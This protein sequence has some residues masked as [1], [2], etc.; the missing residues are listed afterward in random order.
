MAEE[1]KP[2]G[3]PP[4]LRHRRLVISTNVLVQIVVLLVVVV[5]VNWLVARHYPPRFD[6]TSTHYYE[7]APKTR[8]VLESLKEPLDIV[9]FIPTGSQRDYVEK[10]LQD[11]RNLLKEFEVVG[12]KN[13][14]LE[15]VD[16]QRDLARA[17]ELVEKY[18][19]DSPD[20]VI[21]ASGPRHKFVKLDDMVEIEQANYTEAPRVKAFKGEGVFL[22]AIQTVT[23]EKPAKVYFLSGHGERDSDSTDERDGYSVFASYLKRDNITVEKWNWATKQAWPTDAG[24]LVVAGPR[25]KFSDA[26]LNALD[27]YL[28]NKGRVLMLL[29]PRRQTGVEQFL[30]KYG[31]QVDDDLVVSPLLGM[32][33][34]TA[35][36]SEYG[37]HPITA[38]MD[39]INTSFPYARS[40]REKPE[41]PAGNTERPDVVELVRTPESFWGE[42]DYTGQNL[43]FDSKTDV[44]GPVCLGVAVAT[45]KPGGVDIDVMRMVV[46]G[47]ASFVDNSNIRSSDGNADLVM[48]AINWLLKR[49]QLVAVSPKTPEEFHLD[50]SVNQ[51]R[52]V[53][54]LVV[55]VLP[56]AVA[57]TGIIVWMRRRR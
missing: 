5:M 25:T 57:L 51:V 50:M 47:T 41:P 7:L 24:V 26:E 37:R 23:E 56:L 11:V 1:L 9:V 4:T 53:Y 33:N 6:W 55:V 22:S 27:E 31:V 12:K 43:T 28:K 30:G 54:A 10:T 36:G 32:I 2:S 39:G 46:F 3:P 45:R 38:K 21:F 14:R 35:L 29:D 13:L 44:A 17:R 20:V 48:N 18:Q 40:V 52:M 42:T 16:P 49:E 8:Q 15:Y 19:L 34:V